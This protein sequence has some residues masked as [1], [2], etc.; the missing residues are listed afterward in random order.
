MR[1]TGNPVP[2]STI[3]NVEGHEDD[4]MI[5]WPT[6]LTV[7]PEQELRWLGRYEIPGTFDAEHYFLLRP[8][9]A[10]TTFI[11]GEKVS[12]LALWL[13]DV[14]RLKPNLV[15]MNNALKARSEEP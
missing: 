13:Y 5:F 11:Q 3:K 10:G 4:Q 15:S 7:H 12:G 8:S 14:Q 6:V 1:L 9:G 2:G